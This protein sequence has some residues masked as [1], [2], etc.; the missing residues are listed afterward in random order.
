MKSQMNFSP[1]ALIILAFLVVAP[2]KAANLMVRVYSDRGRPVEGA[3]ASV[4]RT[5]A[6]AAPY[7]TYQVLT[8]AKGRFTLNVPDTAT[9]SVCVGSW[10]D[11]LL[12]SCEWAFGQSLVKIVTG[13]Q[14]AS[15]T[16]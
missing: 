15:I 3:L 9:Y 16:I 8:D 6:T 11:Q 5:V 13:Q 12:N 4:Q 1:V 14:A 2:I 10:N 7:S